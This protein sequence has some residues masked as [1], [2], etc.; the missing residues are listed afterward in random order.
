[1]A[2]HEG[3][4]CLSSIWAAQHDVIALPVFVSKCF[5]DSVQPRILSSAS[6]QLSA[7]RLVPFLRLCSH[8]SVSV[9]DLSKLNLQELTPLTPEVI[10][11]QATI[12]IGACAVRGCSP[13]SLVVTE[14]LGS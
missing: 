2:V 9:Q 10:S 6:A 13:H 12:N 14:G 3:D 5:Q 8:A 7:A 1:M 4:G 11:R